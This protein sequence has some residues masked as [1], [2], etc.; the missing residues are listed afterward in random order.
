MDAQAI[1]ADIRLMPVVVI[2]NENDAVPLARA[3][4]A[5]GIG[6]IEITLRSPVALASIERVVEEVPGMIV[7]AGSVRRAEQ[8]HAAA[9]AG[10]SFTVSPGCSAGL[11]DAAEALDLAFVPGAAT[12]SEM[13][14]LLDAGYVLQKFFP[15]ELQGGIARIQALSAPLPEVRFFPT[16]GIDLRTARDYLACEAVACIGGSWFVPNALVSAGEFGKI[17][18]LVRETLEQVVG[19]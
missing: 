11:L 18:S 5:G 12:A 3:L 15:A 2:Q 10:A 9:S 16:G 13:I 14:A 19:G 6:A 17:A 4:L 7:G 1:L 8:M